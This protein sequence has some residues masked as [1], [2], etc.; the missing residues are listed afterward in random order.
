MAYIRKIQISNFRSYK[1]NENV[2]K[3]IKNLNMFTGKNNSGKTNILRAI[4]LF[5][6]PKEYDPKLDMN[7]IKQLTGGGTKHPKIKLEIHDE[8]ITINNKN[9]FNIEL[10]LNFKVN[11]NDK[12]SYKVTQKHHEEKLNS[13]KKIEAYLNKT[14]K[15]VYLST[16][17][18]GIAEQAYSVVNDMILQ[19]Y[20]K[21]NNNIKKSIEEFETNYENLLG[22][23][24]DNI[25]DLEA[26][27]TKQFYIFKNNDI[28][29]TPRLKIGNEKEISDFLLE[30]IKLELDDSYSQVLKAKGAGVQR[31]SLILLSLFLMK[32]LYST[33]NKIILLDEPEA[34][35][36]PLL[37][38]ELKDTIE[39]AALETNN[40]QIFMTSHSR[41]FLS[42]I[43]NHKYAFF[44]I[45]QE[46]E[47][48]KYERSINDEDINKFS[49]IKEFDSSTK[50]TVLKNYGLLDNIDDHDKIIICEGKTD[51]NY[52]VKILEGKPFRPQIRYGKYTDY[53]K[54]DSEESSVEEA[55]S[56]SNYFTK[57]TESII[58]ILLY[59]DRVSNVNRDI[60][61][62]V[63]GDKAGK[64]AKKKIIS[65]HYS[66]LNI[67]IKI[68]PNNK[69]IEDVVFEKEEFISKVLKILKLDNN[70][71]RSFREA[72]NKVKDNE[73][74]IKKTQQFIEMF[75]L[76]INIGEVK[77]D[78]SN[79]L[80]ENN[81]KKDWIIE[82]L[83]KFFKF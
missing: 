42:E 74:V 4:N 68:L 14:F 19:Y 72:I 41:E 57:G 9:V 2:L 24:K 50:F 21:K 71:E 55:D 34:F 75:D 43:N 38:L 49:V 36:Y 11:A 63:D 17:D 46:Y 45:E 33:K 73:S 1:N 15:C 48:K 6:N 39:N 18:E 40:S 83:N 61:I 56:H 81:I 53:I 78:L 31:T 54:E 66:N 62:L 64:D 16:T 52:L 65:R 47:K 32:E 30:N 35:L 70:N 67:D 25:E 22:A 12:F 69:Q 44:N 60:F 3:D 26:E 58:P 7:M 29:I 10:D 80:N 23:F 13:S 51:K 37:I 27:L 76:E 77:R 59:L 79:N 8:N 28:D 82:D 5:F 20:K